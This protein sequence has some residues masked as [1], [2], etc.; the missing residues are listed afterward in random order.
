MSTLPDQLMTQAELCKW[1]QKSSSWIDKK[2]QDG[3]LPVHYVGRSRR[4]DPAEVLRHLDA[5][6]KAA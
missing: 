5:R 4:F 6:A 2:I 1:L 3:E